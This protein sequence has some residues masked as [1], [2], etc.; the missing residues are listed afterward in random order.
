[1]DWDKYRVRPSRQTRKPNFMLIL[2]TAFVCMVMTANIASAGAEQQADRL[3][4]RIAGVPLQLDDPRR[5]QMIALI[6]QGKLIDAAAIALDDDNFYNVTLKQWAATL[7]NRDED[8]F[9]GLNDMTAMI[10]GVVRDQRDFREILSGDFTYVGDPALVAGLPPADP[11]NNEHYNFLETRFINLRK[12]ILRAEPQRLDMPDAAGVLTSR[13]WGESFLSAGTNRR[14]I[15]FAFQEFMC[16]PMRSMIDS[17]LP[18]NY[19]RRDVDRSPGGSSKT[20]QT[21]CRDCHAGMDSIGGAYSRYDFSNMVQ[22]SPASIAQK[23][24]KN[25]NVF[26]AGHVTT[27]DSWVNYWTANGNAAMGWRGPTQGNGVRQFGQML[28]NSQAF[29]RCMSYRVFTQACRRP[30]SDD[31]AQT[32]DGLATVFEQSNYSMKSLY[33][34]AAILHACLGD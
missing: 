1:M 24:N 18:D 4:L 30:P 27:D 14:A 10:I 13:K 16:M 3:F 29:S 8:P 23:M 2:L 33:G 20:Y 19:V 11:T 21:S 26:P 12:T 28:A 15:E 31:E 22:Y 9:T 25:G 5:P 7:T 34:N 32:V 6:Q 17:S